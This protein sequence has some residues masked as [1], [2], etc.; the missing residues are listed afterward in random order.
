[1]LRNAGNSKNVICVVAHQKGN[2]AYD[3][4][5]E[6]NIYSFRAFSYLQNDTL[7][8]GIGKHNQVFVINE[9]LLEILYL[10]LFLPTWKHL[11]VYCWAA[12]Y[13]VLHHIYQHCLS[14][15]L[16]LNLF[17]LNQQCLQ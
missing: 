12:P 17:I 1:M 14:T 16:Q 10:L 11:I 4:Q 8:I 5:F 9:I 2:F 13:D 3:A 6:V 7:F 15:C